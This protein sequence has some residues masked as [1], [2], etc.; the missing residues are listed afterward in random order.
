VDDFIVDRKQSVV[1]EWAMIDNFKLSA[2]FN[3]VVFILIKTK[4]SALSTDFLGDLIIE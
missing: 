1:F 4:K 3:Q 2:N